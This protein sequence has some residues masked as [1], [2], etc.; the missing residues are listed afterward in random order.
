MFFLTSNFEVSCILQECAR[1]MGAEHLL[2]SSCLP[3]SIALPVS[4]RKKLGY[5]GYVSVH[6]FPTGNN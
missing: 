6:F 3:F 2:F 4:M 1:A 5:R